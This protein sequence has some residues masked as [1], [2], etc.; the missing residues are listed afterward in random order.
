MNE[1]SKIMSK[2][3][4]AMPTLKKSEWNLRIHGLKEIESLKFRVRITITL[5][6][7]PL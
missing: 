5:V 6:K 7:G 2:Q 3:E 4:L 1:Q